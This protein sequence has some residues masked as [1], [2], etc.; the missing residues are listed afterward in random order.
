[1]RRLGLDD[2]NNAAV[3]L[4]DGLIVA[5]PTD[6][7]YGLA[8]RL[9]DPEALDSLYVAKGRPETKPLPVL[10]GDPSAIG[11]LLSEVPP[12]LAELVEQHWPGA[13]TI[14]TECDGELASRVRSSDATIG[15]RCP[16]DPTARALLRITGPLCVTSANRS[17]EE[18]CRSAD[19]VIAAFP[20]SETIAAV[21]DGGHRDGEPSTVVSLRDGELH[22]LRQGAIKL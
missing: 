7:V 21:L 6:T 5:I 4:D 19:E 15:I 9:N 2:L 8:A 20:S 11:E 16:D 1:V 10:V 22:V 17:G 3:L 12:K 18:P 13:L 14:V